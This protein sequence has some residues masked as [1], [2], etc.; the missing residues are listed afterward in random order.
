MRGYY[1]LVSYRGRWEFP[2]FNGCARLCAGDLETIS[3]PLEGSGRLGILGFSL[4]ASANRPNMALG[5]SNSG[6]GDLLSRS[7]NQCKKK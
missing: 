4:Q 3:P 7:V 5:C 1:V 6:I 2:G